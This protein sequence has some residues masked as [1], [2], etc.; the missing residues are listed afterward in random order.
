MFLFFEV[1]TGVAVLYVFRASQC[2]FCL[3]AF[4]NC[5]TNGSF[6]C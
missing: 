2:D 3:L 6:T 1:V 4:T 5:N